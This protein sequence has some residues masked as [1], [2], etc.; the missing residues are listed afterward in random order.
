MKEDELHRAGSWNC[1]TQSGLL[2]GFFQD[3]SGASLIEFA[4]IGSLVLAL[5][6][7]LLLALR[8]D[9]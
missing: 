6:L 5:C 1:A 8:S 2:S 4:L 3:D 9:G 7:L